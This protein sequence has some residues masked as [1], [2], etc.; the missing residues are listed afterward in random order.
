MKI[1]D[2]IKDRFDNNKDVEFV[3]FDDGS[4]SIEISNSNGGREIVY[5]TIEDTKKMVE[6]VSG[7]EFHAKETKAANDAYSAFHDDDVWEE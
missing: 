6:F 2:F 4:I 7:A 5:M 1:S 3:I